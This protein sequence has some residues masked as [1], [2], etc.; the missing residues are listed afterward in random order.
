ML[1]KIHTQSTQSQIFG[2][3][4]KKRMMIIQNL[5]IMVDGTK[6]YMMKNDKNHA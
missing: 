3:Y 5:K 4:L 6:Q 2:D 1:I